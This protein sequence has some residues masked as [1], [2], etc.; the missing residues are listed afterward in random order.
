MQ[1][2]GLAPII[3]IL[4]I[5][6]A[7]G[8][9]L[10]Y[11]GYSGK[12]NLPQKS[13]ATVACTEEAKVCPDGTSVG[14]SGPKCEFAPCP[15]PKTDDTANWKTYTNNKHQLSIKYPNN[16]TLKEYSENVVISLW[17]PTQGDQQGFHDGIHLTISSGLKNQNIID[18]VKADIDK[19]IKESSPYFNPIE[20]NQTP[21]EIAGLKGYKYIYEQ[22]GLHT[23]IFLETQSL[24]YIIIDDATSDPTSQGYKKTVDQI[25]S[26]LKFQ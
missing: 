4:L 5:T 6:A 15:S 8:G 1:Q 23:K 18:I 22:A 19:T 25:L 9:Y 13:P 20:E 24:G 3:I 21:V 2:K 26:T 7:I 10:I 14:R 17:G 16:T 11:S 12:I